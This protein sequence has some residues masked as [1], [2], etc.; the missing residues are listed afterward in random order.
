MVDFEELKQDDLAKIKLLF[1]NHCSDFELVEIYKILSTLKDKNFEIE[2]IQQLKSK[3][4]FVNDI[5]KIKP[6]DFLLYLDR[7]YQGFTYGQVLNTEIVRTFFRGKTLPRIALVSPSR[8]NE[9]ITA[10]IQKK[11]KLLLI[12]GGTQDFTYANY[13]GY[14]KLEQTIFRKYLKNFF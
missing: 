6:E 5:R 13:L 10:E 1:K 7:D 4:V 8:L 12:L 11:G 9:D 14:K 3:I 2:N